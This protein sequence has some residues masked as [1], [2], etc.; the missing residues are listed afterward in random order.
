ML[1]LH[2][3]QCENLKN[4]TWGTP[5]RIPFLKRSNLTSLPNCP[6]IFSQKVATL[7]QNKNEKCDDFNWSYIK[8]EVELK[9]KTFR[10]KNRSKRG[11]QICADQTHKRIKR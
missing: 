9:E 11:E 8:N 10:L 3:F 2:D 7:V 4:L 5:S 1:K 6:A